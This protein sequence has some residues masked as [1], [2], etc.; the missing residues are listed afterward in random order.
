MLSI[1]IPVKNFDSHLLIKELHAQGEALGI[2][3]EIL[4]AEDGTESGLLHLNHIADILPNC[5]R[6]VNNCNI[7]RAGIRNQLASEAQYTNLIFIDCDAVVEKKDFLASYHTALEKQEVVCGGLYHAAKQP[8]EQ[9]SLRYRY[10][11]SADKTRCAAIRSK[12]PYDKFTSF[13]FAIK[14][15]TFTSILFDTSITKYGYEDVLF[16]KELERRGV[17]ILHIENRLL[18]CGLED[19]ATF[20]AKT[21]QSL[22]TLFEIREKVGHTPLLNIANKLSRFHLT[23]LFM[24]YWHYRR[25]SYRK[26]LLGKSPSLLK[27]NIYKLGYYLSISRQ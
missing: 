19:N 8:N 18:H 5:R 25:N 13:N 9:C 1:L 4:V 17:E 27:F 6:I 22:V 24:K 12:V 21:E 20:L 14:K 26:N 11:K 16:G 10:E 15:E 2:P 3:F 7:G 23:R